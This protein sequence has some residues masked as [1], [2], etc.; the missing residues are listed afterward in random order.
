MLVDPRTQEE[1]RATAIIR[2]SSGMEAPGSCV[3]VVEEHVLL[4][5][6]AQRYE[7]GE[8]AGA[9]LDVADQREVAGYV[10]GLLDVAVHDGRR[11]A[12]PDLV[13]RG[14]DLDPASA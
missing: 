8:A 7:L 14:D 4:V 13:G 3:H 1:P 10:P 9:L 2:R 5:D 11:R 12:Q 6:E